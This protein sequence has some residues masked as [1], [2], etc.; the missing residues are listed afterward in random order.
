[1]Q[2]AKRAQEQRPVLVERL[3]LIAQ[4]KA[5]KEAHVLRYQA[6]VAGYMDTLRARA[7][8]AFDKAQAKL[9]KTRVERMQQLEQL[10]MEDLAK[11]PDSIEIVQSD[12]LNMEV[13]KSYETEYTVAINILEWTVGENVEISHAEFLCFV[14][15]EWDW[16]SSFNE[17]SMAYLPKVMR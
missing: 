17:L 13:P 14:R 6:A 11:M 1:M 2:A 9:T 7:V 12:R 5:N 8:E 10:Q 4:L 15:D 3:K 16:S